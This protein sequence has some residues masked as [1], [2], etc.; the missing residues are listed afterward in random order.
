MNEY[1]NVIAHYLHLNN[2]N[3]NVRR[4]LFEKFTQPLFNVAN[5]NT[6]SV[7]RA[8]NQVIFDI[9]N[10][11]RRISIS[12]IFHYMYGKYIFFVIFVSCK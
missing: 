8:P 4:F 9:V 1:V 7:L 10:R 3:T 12:F 2:V 6:P 11:V 5:Q